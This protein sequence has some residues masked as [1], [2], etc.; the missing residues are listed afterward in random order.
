MAQPGKP[1]PLALDTNLPLDLAEEKDFAHAFREEFQQRG[2][3]LIIPPT[4]VAELTL[5]ATGEPGAKANLAMRALH[6]LREWG[7]QPYHLRS[8]G[9]GIAAEFSR[10]LMKRGLLPEGEFN[11]GVILAETSLAG[12][13]ML[14][15]SDHHL[16]NIPTECLQVAF[17]AADLNFVS[18]AHPRPLLKAL[19]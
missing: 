4:V 18:V 15:T 2:Y 10:G 12:I 19:P 16:L 7:I 14:V 8:A 9:H 1:K 3:S 17:D 6:S 11:D 5:L 13:R